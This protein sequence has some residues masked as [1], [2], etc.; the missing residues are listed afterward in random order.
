MYAAIADLL[1][2]AEQDLS[3]RAIIFT[4]SGDAFTSGNDI[5]DFLNN[6]IRDDSAPVFRVLHGLAKS[7][8]PLIAAVNGMAIG[9]GTTML[10]HCD[11]VYTVPD[12]KFHMPFVNLALVPEAASSL[13]LP[14][15]VGYRKAAEMLL[16]GDPFDS[17]TASQSGIVNEIVRPE[18]LLARARETAEKLADKPPQALRESKALMRR[19]SEEISDRISAEITTFSQRLASPEAKEVFA[20]FLEKRPPNF[21]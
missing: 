14:R 21:G 20:A 15:Q 8:V 9:I 2:E 13:L 19:A 11:F 12:A 5:Q 1:E 16:L 10:M 7:T 18:Q 3:I 4:G 17:E 6:P